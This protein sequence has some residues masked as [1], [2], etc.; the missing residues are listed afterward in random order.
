MRKEKHRN[1]EHPRRAV[2]TV[3]CEFVIL[4]ETA[5]ITRKGNGHKFQIKPL[6]SILH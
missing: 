3:N 4:W 6:R 1:T 2:E 5:S